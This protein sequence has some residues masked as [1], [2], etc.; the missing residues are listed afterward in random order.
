MHLSRRTFLVSSVALAMPANA[1]G[2]RP[3][4]LASFEGMIVI[5]GLGAMR[6]PYAPEDHLRLSDRAW[7]EIRATGVTAIRDTVFPVGNVLDAWAEYKRDV[8]LRQDLVGANP[9]RLVLV[10]SVDDI[11]RA[12]R[13][14]KLGILLGTQ[15]TSMIGAALDRLAEMKKD[16]VLTIQ[17]TYNNRNLAGDGALE[18]ADAGLSN[19]G[20]KMIE[21]IESEK[22]LLDLSHGGAKTMAEAVDHAKRPLVISHTGARRLHDHVR[23]TADETMRAVADKGGVIGVY[24]M[25]FLTAD[26]VPRGSDLIRHIEHVTNVV[27]EDH[28]GLGSDNGPL[29]QSLDAA[30]RERMRNW[31]LERIRLGIAAPGETANTLTLVADYNS[32]D[33]YRRLR[34]DLRYRGWKDARLEKLFGKNFLRVYRDAWGA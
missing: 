6:D 2:Q 4:S 15:D 26:G 31:Q 29:P 3:P 19:L 13:E 27:G 20:R 34:R 24:F 1:F 18:S 7:A 30:S 16:G 21:R 17:L 25:P 14:K 11:M 5:D 9:D 22:L 12:K 8:Q 23:N 33:R 32:I 28:V 10:R